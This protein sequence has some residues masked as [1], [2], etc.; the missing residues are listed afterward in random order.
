MQNTLRITKVITDG[1]GNQ[2]VIKYSEIDV[3]HKINKTLIYLI[4][5]SIIPQVMILLQVHL[6]F[7]A[8]SLNWLLR[9]MPMLLK[10]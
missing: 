5:Q 3:F 4:F 2:G 10:K 1:G 7:G 9:N 8:D 6:M